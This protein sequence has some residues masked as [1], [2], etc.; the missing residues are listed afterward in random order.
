MRGFS[1]VSLMIIDEASRVS[2]DMWDA[3]WPMIAVSRGDLWM[4]STPRGKQ[5]FFWREWSA[6]GDA[7][8]RM[9]VKAEDCPR[10]P[11]AF[12]DEE[13]KWKTRAVFDQEYGCQFSDAAGAVFSEEDMAACWTDEVPAL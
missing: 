12:L 13:R 11:A 10:I 7:W 3:V 2:D 6:G 1:A 8:F 9:Q 4:L 5:G